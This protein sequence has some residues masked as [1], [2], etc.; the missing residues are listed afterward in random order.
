MACS[1]F[2]LIWIGDERSYDRFHTDSA[3]IFRVSQV[4]C[5]EGVVSSYA[6]TPAALA[7]TLM[8]ECPEVE[9]ATSVRGEERGTLVSVDDKHCQ[10]SRIGITDTRFFQVFSFPLS[11]GNPEAAL[12]SP[13]TIVLS[14]RTAERYFGSLIPIGRTLTLYNADFLVTGVFEN[15]PPNSHFHFEMLC[16]ISSFD[17]W[18]QTDWSWSPV[19]TYVRVHRSADIQALQ[20]KLNDIAGTRMFGGDYGA[21]V[22]KGNFK[23][24]PLQA[25]TDIHLH[26]HLH[27]EF[28]ANGSSYYVLFFTLIAGFILVIAAVNYMNLSTARSSSRALEVGIRKTV[29]S[30]RASL[31][32]QFL[33]ESILTSLLALLLAL[34]LVQAFMPAFSRFVG[35]P[36]L[37]IPFIQSPVWVLPLM[38]TAVLIGLIA[39]I[40]PSVFLSSAPPMAALRGKFS[41]SF[42]RSWLRNGL[43]VFQFSLSIVLFSG[44][45]V[46]RKQMAFIQNQDLGFQREHVVVLQTQGQLNQQLP[47]FKDAL[48]NHPE[49]IAA[50]ASSSVP[51][52]GFDSVGFHV[53][54]RQD[55]W[56]ATICIAADV[57]FLDV[58]Q[59]EMDEGRFF[60]NRIKTDS[61]AVVINQCKAISIDSE[62]IFAERILIGG[63]G[64]EPFHVIGVVKN[65][66]YESFHE[67]VKSMGIVLLSREEGWSEDYV[68]IRLHTGH[69]HST[70]ARIQEV[71]EEFIPGSPFKAAFLDT[72]HDDMYR[73]ERRTGRIFSLFTL[74]ALFVTGLG[75]LGLTSY[76][77]G[78]R[79]KEFGIRKILGADAASIFILLT[80]EYQKLIILANIIAW[81]LA[82]LLM[83]G[84]LQSFAFRTSIGVMT[85]LASGILVIFLSFL[86]VIYHSLKAATADPVEALRYE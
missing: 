19:K 60:N 11:L 13:H 9:S 78:Q 72:I 36:W 58:M 3:R 1:L 15:M 7:E 2:I 44:T 85:F 16:S 48:L 6:N 63:S 49:I 70:M 12:D 27:G 69:M 40:Y 33:S 4:H 32:R 42:K 30:T 73:N 22:A 37:K 34:L 86:A 43:V 54:G 65:F 68:S 71:W 18:S 67:P 56:P 84:W 64:Q 23:T 31:I 10:E 62:D 77:A 14:E 8:R 76:A 21:W 74:L 41:P 81:P 39:G 79:K 83:R 47:A 51:G 66:H 20:A 53:E 57:D 52:K 35:K 75:L 59:L 25:L 46:V 50:S 61:Q 38:L 82:Y 17:Q 45:L 80:R 55:S 24:L 29:G 5:V 28:E 26:S